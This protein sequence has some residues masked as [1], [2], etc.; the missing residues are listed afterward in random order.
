[1]FNLYPPIS[2]IKH[3]NKNNNFK[4][5]L[6]NLKQYFNKQIYNTK[7]NPYYTLKL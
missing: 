4:K 5:K 1:M 7:F 3:K 2:F 6:K